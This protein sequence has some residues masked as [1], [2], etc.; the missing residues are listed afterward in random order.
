MGGGNPIKRAV[1]GTIDPWE[2]GVKSLRSGE[3]PYKGIGEAGASAVIFEPLK[4]VAGTFGLEGAENSI[5]SLE[6]QGAGVRNMVADRAS[7]KYAKQKAEAASLESQALK[8]KQL[9]ATNKKKQE[10]QA[11]ADALDQERMAQG[12]KSRTL[13]TGGMDLEEDEN[14]TVSRRML[15]GR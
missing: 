2:K 8:Q 14:S 12:K 11:A 15:M 5:S 13:L 10:A 7:G 1:K 3:N 6:A 9:S 4:Q